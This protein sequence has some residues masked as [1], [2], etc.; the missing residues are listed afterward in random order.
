MAREGQGYPCC[1]HDMMMMKCI[2]RDC[3]IDSNSIYVDLTLITQSKRFIMHLFDNTSIAQ[4][5]D[6]RSCSRSEFR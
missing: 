1:Q 5:L 3:I 2:L 4:Y 6:K